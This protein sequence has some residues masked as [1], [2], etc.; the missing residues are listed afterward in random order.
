MHPGNFWCDSWALPCSSRL[1]RA[2]VQRENTL[3][4]PPAPTHRCAPAPLPRRSRL[5]GSVRPVHP[6]QTSPVGGGF[7]RLRGNFSRPGSAIAAQGGAPLLGCTSR[8]CT[9]APGVYFV[10]GK[11]GCGGAVLCRCGG[12][13]SPLAAPQL[14]TDSL[15]LKALVSPRGL[16]FSSGRSLPALTPAPAGAVFHP[17]PAAFGARRGKGLARGTHPA[18]KPAL[19]GTHMLTTLHTLAPPVYQTHIYTHT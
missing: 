15:P 16:V 8:V 4:V 18:A 9:P 14:L 10:N 3:Q 11:P 2:S 7:R 19:P 17:I 13:A 12:A 5:W 1:A 6:A